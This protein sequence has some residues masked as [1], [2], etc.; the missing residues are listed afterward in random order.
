[1][2][3]EDKFTRGY[4]GSLQRTPLCAYQIKMALGLNL[5]KNN[6]ATFTCLISKVILD[7]KIPRPF[8][9]SLT[10]NTVLS[11]QRSVHCTRRR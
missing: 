3:V 11:S 5:V 9:T 6:I 8:L 4:L 1:M 7:E 2:R 10:I